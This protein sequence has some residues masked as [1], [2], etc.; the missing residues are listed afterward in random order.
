MCW[1]PHTQDGL[2]EMQPYR[3]K[4]CSSDRCEAEQTLVIFTSDNGPH[5]EGGAN[6]EYFQSS[7]GLRGIKRDLYEGGIRVPFI[8]R[9]TGNIKPGTTSNH[10]S[11]FWDFFPTAADLAGA[12]IPENIDGISY[13]PTLLG[14]ADRQKQHEYL[15]WEFHEQ[16]SKQAVRMGNWKLVRFFQGPTEL[17]NLKIDLAERHNVSALH[18]VVL[19]K[20]EAY[21]DSARTAGKSFPLQ[22][23]PQ[24]K[25]K[26]PPGKVKNHKILTKP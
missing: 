26:S 14:Q 6:P 12:K 7:G 16:G 24:P 13:L 21:L 15:Y 25:K 18:P 19:K 4:N 17:Y 1:F 23:P 10:L 20:M 3:L 11:A 22:P 9:W 8:V 5:R 2:F